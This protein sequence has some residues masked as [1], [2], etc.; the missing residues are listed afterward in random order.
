MALISDILKVSVRFGFK[1]VRELSV[2]V[3]NHW[4]P[5]PLSTIPSRSLGHGHG[6][7]EALL[8]LDEPVLCRSLTSQ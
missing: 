4:H 5:T 6:W 2:E 7:T 8:K 1:L 3:L